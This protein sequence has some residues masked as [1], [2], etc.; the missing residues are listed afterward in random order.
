M[1]PLFLPPLLFKHLKEHMPSMGTLTKEEDR[2]FIQD[3]E[4]RSQCYLQHV[5][6]GYKGERNE[7]EQR[8]GKGTE[9]FENGDVYNGQWQ[10]GQHHGRGVYRWSWGDIYHGEWFEG[11]MHGFARHEYADGGIFYGNM[12]HNKRE[13][14]GVFLYSKGDELQGF[15][16]ADYKERCLWTFKNG[17][18]MAVR[19]TETPLPGCTTFRSQVSGEGVRWSADRQCAWR[20]LNGEKTLPPISLEEAA[21]ILES[22][23]LDLPY[24]VPPV[25]D[26][27][28]QHMSDEVLA[29]LNQKSSGAAGSHTDSAVTPR[30]DPF[31]D[32]LLVSIKDELLVSPPS[33]PALSRPTTDGTLLELTEMSRLSLSSASAAAG[34]VQ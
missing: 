8:H 21:E 25:R 20:L 4:A 17:E 7:S 26:S 18:A 28:R 27:L 5:L 23:D 33:P 34:S 30:S 13:G 14:R 6:V 9:Y 15:Y 12:K 2:K 31:K 24:T 16:A 19:F 32:E 10:N 11:K 22:L 3:L 1:M 29:W